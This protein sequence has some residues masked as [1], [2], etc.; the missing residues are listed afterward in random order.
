MLYSDGGLSASTTDID[1]W[2]VHRPDIFTYV[3]NGEI[4]FNPESGKQ[5]TSCPFLEKIPNEEKYGCSIYYDRPEDCRFYPVT[6]DQMLKDDCE[7]LEA[8]DLKD[9]R[10]AQ[11]KLNIIMSDS[12]PP[13]E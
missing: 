12:R 7:M 3:K 10:K 1:F 6:I 4:W 11:K 9:S 2:E 8:H 5:L 13:F